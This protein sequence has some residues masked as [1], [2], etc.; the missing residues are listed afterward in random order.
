MRLHG[1]RKSAAPLSTFTLVA[2]LSTF[3]PRASLAQVEGE[4]PVDVEQARV[5]PWQAELANVVGSGEQAAPP[6]PLDR[7]SARVQ[8]LQPL[9]LPE[10]GK[11][12]GGLNGRA[13]TWDDVFDIIGQEKLMGTGGG[14]P[15]SGNAPGTPPQGQGGAAKAA[16]MGP[17]LSLPQGAA[18]IRG[19]GESFS[20]ELSTGI[21]RFQVPF[22]LPA[23]RGGAQPSLGLSYSS[24]GGHGLAGVGW[25][26]GAP[27]ISRQ[28]DRGI[29]KYQDPNV[30]G[31]WHP[32]QDRFVAGT[33]EL[34]PICLV[35][36]TTTA[37]CDGAE[38]GEI[39]PAWSSGWQ[40]FR[41][42]VEGSYL[43]YFWSP[44]HE[45]WRIQGK[46]GISLELGVPLDDPNDRSALE[47]NPSAP[48]QI[49]AWHLVR[50][51][52]AM[53][54]A[55]PSGGQTPRP[56]NL[57][58]YK[59]ETNAGT[60]YLTDIYDTPPAMD[61]ADAPI[62]RY[63]HHTHLRYEARP[64][65]TTSYRRGW[66]ASV[67]LRL[68]GVDVTSY[69]FQPNE[70]GR[71]L[72]RRYHLTYDPS[73]HVSLLGSVQAEGRCPEPIYESG[74][75]G[76]LPV[77]SC[78]R[79]PAMMFG[80]K[81]VAPFRS[82]GSAANPDLPGYEG[83]DDRI[84]TMD[85]SP[86]HS[87]NE[88]QTELAD[89]DSDG[90]PDVVV[91]DPA[92]YGH[93]NHGLF[94]NKGS[95]FAP[96]GVIKVQGVLGADANVI[97]FSNPN[98]S[99]HDVDGDGTIN[100]LHM[101]LVKTYST[102]APRQI[103]GQW[104]WQ[105]KVVTTASQQSP[106]IDFA[107]RHAD[108]RL[109]D[110]NADGLVDV[111]YT[112]ATE[113]QTF[114]SLGRYP[115][116]DGQYGY[117]SWAGPTT[118][119][120][121]NEPLTSCVPWSALPV[122]FSD[123]DVHVA[124][125]N[126][127][128]LPDIVRVRH[129]D[130]RY[131][132]GRGNGYWGTG[133][134]AGCTA[135][136]F[137]QNQHVP[138]EKSPRVGLFGEEPTLLDD[139]NGDG[140]AD[141]VKV[142]FNA[143]DIYLNVDGEGWTER[144]VI[145]NA[146]PSSTITNRVRLT[147][148]NGSGTPDILWGDGYAYKY[149]DLAGGTRPWL[150]TKIENGLGVTTELEYTTSVEQM[151][152][153]EITGPAWTS[154]APTVA[155]LLARVTRRDNLERVGRAAGTYVTEYTYRDPVYD[156]RQREFRGFRTVR[157][158][159]LGD[160][161]SPTSVAESTF[162]LG[163]CV[164]DP[165]TPGS[166]ELGERWRDNPREALKGL[167]VVA[168]TLNETGSVY[169]STAHTTYRL[170]HLYTGLDGRN[171][172]HAFAV[173]TDSFRYD[174]SP[175]AAAASSVEIADVELELTAG[176]VA[177]DPKRAVALRGAGRVRLRQSANVDRFGNALV[178]H[179]HGCT[180]GCTPSDETISVHTTPQLAPGD[181]SGWIWRT[182][183]SWVAGAH[184]PSV[185]RK[186]VAHQHD[187]RGL[188]VSERVHVTGTLPLDRFHEVTGK[189]I[190][191]APANSI[192][193]GWHDTF[194]FEHDAFGTVTGVFGSAGH[195]SSTVLDEAF[196]QLVVQTR[197]SSGF[198]QST[199]GLAACGPYELTS[200]AEYDRGLGAV[201]R[202]VSSQGA[203][204]T[205]SYDG[206]GRVTAIRQPSPNAFGTP[207]AMPS[208]VFEYYL[209][210]PG[211][212]VARVHQ[213]LQDGATGAGYG[214]SWSFVDGMGRTLATMTAAEGGTWIVQGEVDH[215]AKGAVSRAYQN[216][217]GGAPSLYLEDGPYWRTD[218]VHAR[219][220]RYDAFG[221]VVEAS[222]LDGVTTL[223]NVHHAMSTDAWDAADLEQTSPHHGT[224]STVR[225]DGHGRRVSV[226]QRVH[227][228]AQIE[229]HET[230]TSYLPTGEPAV[231]TRS[232][233]GSTPVV[234]WMRY[235]SFGHMVLNVEP[236]TT[237]NYN[238]S[239]STDPSAMKTWRYAY[240]RLGQLVG[241]SDPRGC[242][243]NYFYLADGRPLGE[244]YSPC[245]EEHA[246]YSTPDLGIDE[247]AA[248]PVF[249][250]G[251]GLEVVFRH[252]GA[253]PD[254]ASIPGFPSSPSMLGTNAG[255]VTSISDRGAKTV[256][257]Y[258]G[259][260][261]PA[262]VARKIAKP[263]VPA[264][265]LADRYTAHWYLR[266]TTYD[267][268]DR[269]IAE[270]TGAD[271]P[272]LLGANG[273]SLV[274]TEYSTRGTIA[275]VGGSYGP[276]VS[277]VSRN[278]DGLI[279]STTYGDVA[280]TK[281]ELQHDERQ[282]L[283]SVVTRRGAPALWTANPPAYTPAPDLSAGPSV[284]QTE[285]ENYSYVYDL[286]DNPK[287]IVDHR[288]PS[289]WP[290]SF[291]PSTRH[292]YYDDLYRLNRVE[293]VGDDDWVSPYLAEI[294]DTT[295]QRT[296]PS[297]H[298]S[299]AKR[300]AEQT[301]S[302]DALGNMTA[303]GD[304]AHGFYDRSLGTITN[305]GAN[306]GPYQLKQAHENGSTGGDLTAAYDDAGNLLSLA[307]RRNGPCLPTGAICSHRFSYEWDEV[308]LLAR[309][310]RWDVSTPGTATDPL[311]TGAPVVELRY[312]YG[313]DGQR[314]L[315]TA[316]NPSTSQ[317]LHTAYV[318]A[319]LE[320]R[321]A[322]YIG[323][324]FESNHTT[325]ATYLFANGMRLARLY[326][327]EQDLPTLSSGHLHVLLELP[328]HLG[329]SS[330]IIDQATSELV[331]AT[332][333]QAYGAVESDYRP[334][335]WNAYREEYRFTG[336]E[337]D[338]EIGLAYFGARYYSPYLGRW[339]SPDPLAL[340]EP[341][342]ADLNLYAYVHGRTYVAVDPNGL[343]AVTAALVGMGIGALVG[344]T[345]YG[346]GALAGG[347]TFDWGG[348]IAAV[349]MGAVVGAATGALGSVAAIEGA[350]VGAA[351]GAHMGS[352]VTSMLNGAAWGMATGAGA[353]AYISGEKGE[354]FGETLGRMTEGAVVGYFGGL[355]SGQTAGLAIAP[356][357]HSGLV[358][359]TLT[360][361]GA[362][363][364][365]LG[366]ARKIYRWEDGS[367]FAAL[368]AD[369]SWGLIGT[370]LGSGWN[371]FNIGHG[372]ATGNDSYSDE[373]SERKNQHVYAGGFMQGKG[374]AHTQGNVI[375]GSSWMDSTGTLEHEEEHVLTSR[376]FGPVFQST[377]ASW[378]I[379]GAVV[380]GGLSLVYGRSLV[381][382]GKTMGY[383]NNPWEIHAKETNNPNRTKSRCDIAQFC[384]E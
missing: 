81:H 140:L 379:H 288:D 93:N 150:L 115:G 109:M 97:R 344:G 310:R 323:G 168:E 341:G 266:T 42:R 121:S 96:A 57:V 19:M 31:P 229:L 190:A 232:R 320:L 152:A 41:A 303:T 187:A 250:K 325:Q 366:G 241:T 346:G 286:V 292:L 119:N 267:G 50:S 253:D 258:D 87:I 194:S 110:V 79:L 284:F 18:K 16:P 151:L 274:T 158:R 358:R 363:N 225:V 309:A 326:Y 94:F 332:R 148:V 107:G 362:I 203:V 365:G 360:A 210:E 135:G 17:Q 348:F 246:D 145:E 211:A 98:L 75:A 272:E 12:G 174:T 207:S 99:S 160:T 186:Y 382:T 76:V 137:G 129:G 139:V 377:Y 361:G 216:Y 177:S 322:Q 89:V 161:N 208:T 221:R 261:R 314:V 189:A 260:G 27:T 131:W 54:Q 104:F 101:P 262:V 328:D 25:G 82:D 61:A 299:F 219:S 302:Y 243:V 63:A 149:I 170:R 228:G 327:A 144:H 60:A 222:G 38:A 295:G 373:H 78:P 263:G 5:Q 227:V 383:D 185:R 26:I 90:L 307:L 324:E 367:G 21:A 30:G 36:G 23:A 213:R 157:S 113:V 290:T 179:N 4:K 37:T 283:A 169:Q 212:P 316:V 84:R 259:R 106:K 218:D 282:R 237:K 215:D 308:G 117:A 199:T 364:A 279:E 166:C 277:S 273:S 48:A 374:F 100:L 193:D 35:T 235:D 231:I 156:G 105:G 252:D 141:L 200:A 347:Q 297:P 338:I 85:A 114:L 91:T 69:D 380:G 173:A 205:A 372:I 165:G 298:V 339:T 220:S 68:Q 353:A 86:P 321:R 184:T 204:S 126:G 9:T 330:F 349:G 171:V 3:V 285:L 336:K 155:H 195:C 280:H 122:R 342:R 47:S 197:T 43:R 275:S 53:G 176:D 276:L 146:P 8:Q 264:S 375:S 175:F 20:A 352:M 120:I 248:W 123:P 55:N 92:R 289:A 66:A 350:S 317:E 245:R 256:Y 74:P 132:P 102:Y 167:P 49:Y 124:D 162:L 351:H 301:F 369:S 271:V 72:L 224:P 7:A 128:G 306:A 278:A 305:G 112:A 83:F 357:P 343:E 136:S 214:E 116:G 244:D 32:E 368:A 300:V 118:A 1:M 236:N 65:T 22:E 217:Y 378:L 2:F 291:K 230:T 28:I 46:N 108:M 233:P 376:V 202:L 254:A 15:A 287:E 281:T 159:T 52:D 333:Y 80:Y 11:A 133:D 304:D 234:R 359:H 223:H 355:L 24:S 242:G 59:Y 293:Y 111:V 191:P 6:A 125:M 251:D 13:L 312:A 249:V 73:S 313:A 257:H 70:A 294:A 34:V 371:L 318:F 180:E 329:S 56:V 340:H 10:D 239:P 51:Y 370:T 147:D 247:S 354:S 143:V 77:T 134:R 384:F 188:A 67:T 331:E 45:T 39:M 172:R 103:D 315:K 226:I 62:S 138:M 265:T 88:V 209:P 95:R 198:P 14:D 130:I 196:A 335:R 311:P 29:P 127:D 58:R 192:S 296:Q 33:E 71:R 356:S 154:K 44:N 40:Y 64:D 178:Q 164:D 181:P 163:E 238:P 345:A 269:P 206:F 183:E 337:E 381:G 201:T 268:A 153:A 182:V 319:S 334:D 142:R 240:D 270:S 255:H